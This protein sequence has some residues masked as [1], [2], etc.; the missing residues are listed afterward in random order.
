MHFDNTP[1]CFVY[2]NENRCLVVNIEDVTCSMVP[3]LG[4]WNGQM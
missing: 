1:P 2:I 3:H 4:E